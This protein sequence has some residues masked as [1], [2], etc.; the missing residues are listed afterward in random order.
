MAEFISFGQAGQTTETGALKGKKIGG[1]VKR[2][3]GGE[4]TP[5][6]PGAGV[7]QRAHPVVQAQRIQAELFPA[8]EYT[9]IGKRPSEIPAEQ[10]PLA[11]SPE[12]APSPTITPGAGAGAGGGG[13]AG[14]EAGAGAPTPE[15]VQLAPKK[16][17]WLWIGAGVAGVGLLIFLLT[18]SKKP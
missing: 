15:A 11:P 14:T 7:Q 17:P 3:E 8:R 6:A 10:R 5:S 12:V 1:V 18:R 13:G 2:K 9:Y 16:I 4:V